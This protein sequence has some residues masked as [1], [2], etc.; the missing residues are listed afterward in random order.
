VNI[1]EHAWDKQGIE[2]M[3]ATRFRHPLQIPD[4]FEGLGKFLENRVISDGR[5]QS[6]LTSPACSAMMETFQVFDQMDTKSSRNSSLSHV[7]LETRSK[8]H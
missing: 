1:D 7:T 5:S 8:D 3:R 2:G 4:F 6:R